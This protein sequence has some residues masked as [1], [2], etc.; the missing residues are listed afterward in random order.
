MAHYQ[1]IAQ[2]PVALV[3]NA[4]PERSGP[5]VEQPIAFEGILRGTE[6]D[7][8]AAWPAFVEE[9]SFL[10]LHV[11]RSVAANR[12]E[13]MDAY[14]VILEEL[15]RDDFRRLRGYSADPRSKFTT[16]LVVVA[17]RI[18]V[19]LHRARYG[20]RR[21]GDSSAGAE[22]RRV[23]RQLE[24][25]VSAD[26]DLATVA[27][28]SRGLPDQELIR[29]ELSG[30]LSLVMGRLAAED[31]LLLKLRF[32][33]GM[34]AS[35]IAPILRVSSQFQVYRRINALLADLRQA[36]LARGVEGPAA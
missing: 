20:R 24:D 1:T 2:L 34:S 21:E 12:D 15:S 8:E 9:F 29:G 7:R 10:L 30:A 13:A 28:E 26:T 36:L 33:D 25:L 17:R 27:D 35:E 14:A 31:R 4:R 18:C 22:N 16:W 6:A 32:E 3:S 19:D 5:P 11:A 23:R